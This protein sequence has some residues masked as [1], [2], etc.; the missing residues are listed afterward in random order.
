MRFTI[1]PFFLL[2]FMVFSCG[3]PSDIGNDSQVDQL[4]LKDSKF[5][6]DVFKIFGTWLSQ[7]TATPL[8]TLFKY[9]LKDEN[10]RYKIED[11][12][13]HAIKIKVP[14][15][16]FG[17]LIES[18]IGSEYA[19]YGP[20]VFNSISVLT[21]RNKKP[22]A[23]QAL[24]AYN[25]MNTRD[26]VLSLV[27]K[28]LGSPTL[29]TVVNEG[30]GLKALEWTLKDRTIQIVSF[31]AMEVSPSI[32]V[33][34]SMVYQIDF[35]MIDNKQKEAVKNAHFYHFTD[36][37]SLDGKMRDYRYFDLQKDQLFSDEFL[38]YSEEFQRNGLKSKE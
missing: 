4:N 22:V 24:A 29:E 15:E 12:V 30:K 35:L 27:M 23:Y 33:P 37:I 19:R 26:S 6:E 9:Q 18:P 5:E 36:S 17:Y 8:D 34:D 28:D 16:D 13:I 32:Q 3:N 7:E 11:P 14:K 31:N 10:L 25:Q 21:D 2:I 1:I 38:L 20:M